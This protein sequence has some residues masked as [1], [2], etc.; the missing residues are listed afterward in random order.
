MIAASS[1]RYQ[2]D[3]LQREGGVNI[4]EECRQLEEVM[5]DSYPSVELYIM[6][7]CMCLEH[8]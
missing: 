7:N 8:Y 6:M 1:C 3:G 4:V 5:C 2:G